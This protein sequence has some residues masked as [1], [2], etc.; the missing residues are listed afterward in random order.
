MKK[1]TA[2]QIAIKHCRNNGANIPDVVPVDF[3]V[4]IKFKDD[5]GIEYTT[6]PRDGWHGTVRADITSW[7]GIS[8]GAIHYYAKIRIF[9]PNLIYIEDGK[10][11][12]ASIGGYFDRHK[13]NDAKDIDIE[14]VRKLTS[15][16][17]EDDPE[18]WR[19][20]DV[21]DLTNCWEDEAELI[22][23]VKKII[24]NRFKGWKYEIENSFGGTIAKS[25]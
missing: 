15:K 2:L 23:M 21:G 14:V 22:A 12:R 11:C 4:G 7:R 5:K 3:G 20:Y 9:E 13:P 1:E 8:V 17:I 25:R 16:E 24:R 19:G 10:E 18:R 6:A